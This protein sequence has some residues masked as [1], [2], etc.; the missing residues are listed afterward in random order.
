[1]KNHRTNV[2]GCFLIFSLTVVLHGC[3]LSGIIEDAL[4]DKTEEENEDGD[5]QLVTAKIDGRDFFARNDPF[6]AEL[7]QLESNSFLFEITAGDLQFQEGKGLVGVAIGLVFY[8]QNFS[9]LAKGTVLKPAVVIEDLLAADDYAFIDDYYVVG[10]VGEKLEDVDFPYEAATDETIDV[11]I[12]E[13]DHG[14]KRISGKF[15]FTAYDEGRDK[16]VKVTDGEFK[17]ISWAD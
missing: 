15:E 11:V 13:I 17:N 16:H 7:T 8:G 6:A 4:I 9:S 12:T 5:S 1:M 14:N 3:D 10:F 2:F